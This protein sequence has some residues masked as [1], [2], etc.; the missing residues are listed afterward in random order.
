M[1]PVLVLVGVATSSFVTWLIAKRSTSGSIST[2]DAASL[3]AESNK[4][5]KE[6]RDRAETLEKQLEEVNDK[7][8]AMTEELTKLR[9]NS[10]VMVEKIEELK[11]IIS[12][13]RTE[14]KRLLDLKRS[15]S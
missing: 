4:L 14:N 12:E 6:Y 9:V 2:S 13:L 7:L 1:A 8:Q 3:W 11:Q 5:R 10:D 15:V